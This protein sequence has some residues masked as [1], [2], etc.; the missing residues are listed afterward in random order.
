MI[1]VHLVNYFPRHVGE[2][3]SGADS[4]RKLNLDGIDTCDMVHDHVERPAIPH[5]LLPVRFGKPFDK[6]CEPFGSFLDARGQQV[7]SAAHLESPVLIM[8][9]PVL[10]SGAA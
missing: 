5:C 9:E 7:S 3:I 8:S 10:L 4:L 6:G 1:R 2:C